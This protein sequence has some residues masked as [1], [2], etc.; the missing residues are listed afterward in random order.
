M[1][2]ARFHV[3]SAMLVHKFDYL[4][5]YRVF[6]SNILWFDWMVQLNEAV[7]VEI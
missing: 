6:V 2:H 4:L 1:L 3:I 7:Q 5:M